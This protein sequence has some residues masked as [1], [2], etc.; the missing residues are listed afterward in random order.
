MEIDQGSSTLLV[1]MPFNKPSSTDTDSSEP[2]PKK[3]KTGSK[4]GDGS[5]ESKETEGSV[6][7]KKGTVKDKDKPVSK[8]IKKSTG[9]KSGKSKGKSAKDETKAQTKAKNVKEGSQDSSSVEIQKWLCENKKPEYSQLF[10][11]FNETEASVILEI[12]KSSSIT[13]KDSTPPSKKATPQPGKKNMGQQSKKNT[14]QEQEVDLSIVK[15]EKDDTTDEPEFEDKLVPVT[16]P[17]NKPDCVIN[18]P[19]MG[20]SYKATQ[21][22]KRCHFRGFRKELFPKKLKKKVSSTSDR[23]KYQKRRKRRMTATVIL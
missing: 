11:Q 16:L 23:R 8:D 1:K 15:Q 22:I 10:Q 21:M 9:K 13:S 5:K 4:K 2:K 6:S 7:K 12:L 14:G 3:K 17:C 20:T 19:L 18:K